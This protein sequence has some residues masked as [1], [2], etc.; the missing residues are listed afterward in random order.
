MCH[1]NTESATA[2][3]DV[4]EKYLATIYHKRGNELLKI[5]IHVWLPRNKP[6]NKNKHQLEYKTLGRARDPR[7]NG[8]WLNKL[9]E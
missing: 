5:L 2:L 4:S 6:K 8:A 3:S 7:A 9:T 1:P